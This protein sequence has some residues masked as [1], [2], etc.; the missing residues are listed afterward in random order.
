MGC[1]QI[2]CQANIP[3]YAQS[4]RILSPRVVAKMQRYVTEMMDYSVTPPVL[5]WPGMTEL[6]EDI[7]D[8]YLITVVD[9]RYPDPPD[10]TILSLEAALAAAKAAALPKFL[11][12]T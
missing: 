1:V 4:T 6:L 10:Q 8:R 9:G 5:K 7:L 11:P 12:T 3:G 2:T